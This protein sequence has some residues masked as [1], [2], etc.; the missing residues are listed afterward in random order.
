MRRLYSFEK[1]KEVPR[2]FLLCLSVIVILLL[3]LLPGMIAEF[4]DRSVSNALRRLFISV[5]FLLIPLVFFY[6]N[7]RVYLYV[8]SVWIVLSPLFI[9]SIVLY[10]V[11]PGYNLF[12]WILQTNP[13]EAKELSQSYIPM[14]IVFTLLY[15][16]IYLYAVKKLPFTKIPFQLALAGSLLGLLNVGYLYYKKVY[17][18][19][20]DKY[21]FLDRYY[22][23][24]VV[25][26]FMEAYSFIQTNNLEGSKGFSF[27]A[28]K[29]DSLATRQLNVLVIGEASRYASWQLNGCS[30]PTSPRL[31]QRENLIVFPYA[32]AGC[33]N[34][35]FSVPQIITRAN[36]DEMD[37]R[38]KEKSI[39][40]AFKDAGF[41]TVWLSNQSDKEIFYSGITLLHAK[42][43]DVSIFSSTYSPLF[44]EFGYDG[45]LLPL[46]DSILNSSKEN[47]FIVVHT[48][49]SHWNY[50]HRY[51]KKFDYFQPSGDTQPGLYSKEDKEVM[52]NTYNNSIRYADF[53]I[54]SIISMVKKQNA[55]SSVFYV[56]DHGEDVYD[57]D[58]G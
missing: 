9:Y 3:V 33:H 50:A 27:H 30:K 26:G 7:I 15:L 54:D 29:K 56:A 58:P 20:E 45:R 16:F 5:S 48:I 19:N 52:T 44:D 53:I 28:F 49:G 13:A 21:Q 17:Q 46:V 14:Y 40:S 11:R 37:L 31:M 1:G 8:L 32:V 34:T 55:V 47:L 22:P 42:T 39:L 38:F 57:T 18:Q 6:R 43:A 25:G 4:H 10:D 35:T 51:P 12:F 24:S 2:I 36:P 23:V 41:K